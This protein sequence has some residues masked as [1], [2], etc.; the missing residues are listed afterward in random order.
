MT[1]VSG[2]LVCPIFRVLGKKEAFNY[3]F[4]CNS[5]IFRLVLGCLML[6][7]KGLQR[8]L[9]TTKMTYLRST[10]SSNS[11][12]DPVTCEQAV[13]EEYC[14]LITS[15]TSV[16]YCRL[17]YVCCTQTEQCDNASRT[18]ITTSYRSVAWTP[19]Q[20]ITNSHLIWHFSNSTG[21]TWGLKINYMCGRKRNNF[22]VMHTTVTLG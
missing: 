7:I 16:I 1:N 14:C 13:C 3:R 18:V 11:G 8:W 22:N 5:I 10:R 9:V 19:M 12:L 17:F 4:H 21:K 6:K 20:F 15:T 2:S